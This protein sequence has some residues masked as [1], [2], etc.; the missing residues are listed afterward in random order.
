[1]GNATDGKDADRLKE[2]VLDQG[3]PVRAQSVVD[4]MVASTK[5]K[6][7]PRITFLDENKRPVTTLRR[8]SL[9]N[10]DLQD[11]KKLQEEFYIQLDDASQAGKKSVPLTLFAVS[12]DG[13]DRALEGIILYETSPGRFVSKPQ[14]LINPKEKGI[15]DSPDFF[16]I[17]NPVLKHEVALGETI[18]VENKNG[19]QKIESAVV[20]IPTAKLYQVSPAVPDENGKLVS[21]Q[22]QQPPFNNLMTE[23]NPAHDRVAHREMQMQFDKSLAGKKVTWT[24]QPFPLVEV[25][26]GAQPILQGDLKESPNHKDYFESSKDLGASGFQRIS[27]T[28]AETFIDDNGLTAVR[29]NLP[30]IAFNKAQVKVQVEGIPVPQEAA[31]FIVPAVVVIDPGHG[32]VD[33]IKVGGSDGNHAVSPSGVKEKEMTLDISRMLRDR[34]KV[35]GQEQN[36]P[37]RVYLTR[38]S[39]VNLSLRA[40]ANVAR[41]M[42]ADNMLTI[43]FNGY[44]EKPGEKEARGTETYIRGSNNVNTKEDREFA[45]RVQNAAYGAIKSHDKNAVDRGIKTA[46]FGTISDPYLGNTQDYH[47]TRSA[48]MEMEFIDVKE[49]DE[50]LN[51]G[52]DHQEVRKDIVNRM[53]GA[54]FEDLKQP[55]QSPQ[56]NAQKKTSRVTRK[57]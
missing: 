20:C 50:L 43:H 8:E 7:K 17:F 39:D 44:P 56:Q 4:E 41:D 30:P 46:N 10:S 22:P 33:N 23:E 3:E 40:R 5:N 57:P 2:M 14:L 52:K 9:E 19:E 29:T 35:M 31:N 27:Q 16:E 55:R 53:A 32:G 34:L 45:Q 28:A 15:F 36:L 38:D 48:Y 13:K 1:M 51:T 49:V 54:I 12:P 24:I 37:I 18:I 11:I 42:G 25:D 21:T 47:P 26:G 6:T